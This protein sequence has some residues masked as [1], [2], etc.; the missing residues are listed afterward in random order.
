M[1]DQREGSDLTWGTHP[2]TPEEVTQAFLDGL[3]Q[4]SP[5]AGGTVED[6]TMSRDTGLWTVTLKTMR[7]EVSGSG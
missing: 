6:Q 4:V 2:P 5:S 3:L 1:R 7:V